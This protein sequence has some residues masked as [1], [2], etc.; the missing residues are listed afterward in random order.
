MEENKFS[1]EEALTELQKIVA[2]LE[3]SK[4]SLDDSLKLYERGIAL[5]RQCNEALDNARQKVTYLSENQL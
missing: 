3:G 4:I 5:V 2:D 1:F